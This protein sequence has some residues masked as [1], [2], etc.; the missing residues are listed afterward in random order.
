MS[1]LAENLNKIEQLL[2]NETAPYESDLL[3]NQIRIHL[4]EIEKAGTALQAQRSD[5]VSA[6]SNSET[7]HYSTNHL[8]IDDNL[9]AFL[10]TIAIAKLQLD[11]TRPSY[12]Q[13]G[14]LA[15]NCNACHQR[16]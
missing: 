12:Y 11:A 15:G 3:R 8:V 16:R 4:E 1:S 13:I 14:R 9:D 2:E 10:N 7:L 6:N 5:R